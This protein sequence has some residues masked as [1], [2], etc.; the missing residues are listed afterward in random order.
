MKYH[1]THHAGKRGADAVHELSIAIAIIERAEEV[2][3]EHGA[4]GVESV[5]LRVGELAGVVPDA[6]SFSFEVA[7]EGTLLCEARMEVSLV[8]ARA[9]CAPCGMEFAVGSPPQLWCPDCDR[10]ITALLSGR[11]LELAGVELTSP[12]E[13]AAPHD[14]PPEKELTG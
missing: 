11:E 8:P 13:A 6:L 1:Q 14:G 10:P 3:R 5:R 7:R 12:D 4:S 2:A 9:Q